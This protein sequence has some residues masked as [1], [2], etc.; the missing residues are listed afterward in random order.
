[1][2]DVCDSAPLK[3]LTVLQ[4]LA[5]YQPTF[6]YNRN[7]RRTLFHI[8]CPL[9]ALHDIILL[10]E[11]ALACESAMQALSEIGESQRIFSSQIQKL[12]RLYKLNVIPDTLR[13][14]QIGT[15]VD[16]DHF[17]PETGRARHRPRS[18]GSLCSTTR[19]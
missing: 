13:T 4:S 10:L 8:F 3:Y 6:P 1:M 5:N 2:S 7:V 18:Q 12:W 19:Q 11:F 17:L 9:D 16:S 15:F 14:I